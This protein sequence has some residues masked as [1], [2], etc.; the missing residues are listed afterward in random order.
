[1]RAVVAVEGGWVESG[2]IMNMEPNRSEVGGKSIKNDSKMF[3][4]SNWVHFYW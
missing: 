2:Y 1:M 3:V 4:L